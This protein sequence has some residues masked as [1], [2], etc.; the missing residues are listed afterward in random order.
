MEIK[1]K[2]KFILDNSDDS[3]LLF[4]RNKLV[5]ASKSFYKTTGFTEKDLVSSTVETLFEHIHPDDRAFIKE[6]FLSGIKKQLQVE[7]HEFRFISKTGNYIWIC[8]RATRFYDKEGKPEYIVLN[9]QDITE[10]KI[11]EKLLKERLNF[12]KK[13]HQ[14]CFNSII[15]RQEKCC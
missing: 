14:Y 4:K 9:C 13:S 15:E 2:L 6:K 5:F 11:N 3:I 8:N 7:K 1:N 12:E 10:S